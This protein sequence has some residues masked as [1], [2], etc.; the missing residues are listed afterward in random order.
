MVGALGM[1]GSLVSYEAIAEGPVSTKNLA[2]KVLA[3]PEG[4]RRVEELLAVQKDRATRVLDE[5]RDVVHA[6]RDRLMERD[7]L[8]GDEIGAVIVE[9]L[10]RRRAASV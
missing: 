1:A 10:E 2:G 9:A 4:K 3:D 8:V 7:E 5:N 6:L